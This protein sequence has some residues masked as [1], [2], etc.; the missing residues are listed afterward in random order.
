[1]LDIFL[2][3]KKKVLQFKLHNFVHLDAITAR[4]I[5]RHDTWAP[6]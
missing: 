6:Q 4:E 5:A 2:S 1:M 3:G